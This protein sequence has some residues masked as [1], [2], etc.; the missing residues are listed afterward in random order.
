MA[1]YSRNKNS[2]GDQV[3]S[4]QES[5]NT[6]LFQLDPQDAPANHTQQG[7]LKLDGIY[8]PRTEYCVLAVQ[9]A[10]NISY[11]IENDPLPPEDIPF[12]VKQ[13]TTTQPN[14]EIT[15]TQTN[16]IPGLTL[17]YEDI[18]QFSETD[19]E[20]TLQYR[21]DNG[22]NF[23][24]YEGEASGSSRDIAIS[25][26]KAKV[27]QE[28]EASPPPFLE[29]ETPLI[30]EPENQEPPQ[31]VVQQDPP[32]STTYTNDQVSNDQFQ[33][34][35]SLYLDLAYWNR[36]DY[37]L[38]VDEDGIVGP[39]TAKILN[40]V[41]LPKKDPDRLRYKGRLATDENES[42]GGVKLN[43]SNE[44]FTAIAFSND[45]GTFEFDLGGTFDP[46]LTKIEFD[47]SDYFPKTISNVLQSAQERIDGEIIYIFEM[48]TIRLVPVQLE[49]EPFERELLITVQKVENKEIEVGN[50]STLPFGAKIGIIFN[51]LKERLKRLL[52][53]LILGLL[54]KFGAK[55]VR[56]ILDGVQNPVPDTC[57]TPAE[58]LALIRK[59]NQLV[60]Q[61][62]QL[63]EIVEVV[64]KVLKVVRVVLVAVKIGFK[65]AKLLPLA[66]PTGLISDGVATIKRVID[67]S[68]IAIN[69]LIV[70]V[71]V[72]GVLLQTLLDLLNKLDG[73]IQHCAEDD[74]SGISFE[75]IN[76][77]L[78]RLS[79]DTIQETEE[80]E[81]TPPNNLQGGS[82]E[83]EEF[84]VN[85]FLP[86]PLEGE[87]G[88]DV[89]E[90]IFDDIT[91]V[92]PE[93]DTIQGILTSIAATDVPST[94][95]SPTSTSSGN[96]FRGFT[97]EI[98]LDPKSNSKYPKRFAQALNVQKVPVLKSDSS[99]ASNPQVLIDQLKFII[100]SQGLR[101]D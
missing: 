14:T 44:G 27:Q 72:I 38:T 47:S 17:E 58:L 86:E 9:R 36:P 4:I 7:G 25:L 77:E 84:D 94:S 5:L 11:K 63:F 81:V 21:A 13:P 23:V 1:V 43:V 15:T 62:N 59:R 60:K 66:R 93:G 69:F 46:S 101:G 89:Y 85:D 78:N 82:P 49:V 91:N 57:P 34:A 24:T 61:I 26:A 71:I 95:P 64:A 10:Y 67:K 20:V 65:I 75:R 96:T 100:E 70:I 29:G 73:A 6:I 56:Q 97:F 52:I 2:R 53:P 22:Q 74:L 39:D 42:V 32:Y 28:Y 88:G 3:K 90:A 41:E 30:E 68:G 16:D 79:S 99:F 8:G 55:F 40:I 48:G 31:T 51:K 92:F 35:L 50:K 80:G 54:A 45:D 37:P 12:R 87:E 19:W 33:T 98:K 76:D 83:N 18:Y